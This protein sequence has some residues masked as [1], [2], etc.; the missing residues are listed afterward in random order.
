M[1][2]P[3]V[4]SIETLG[5]G[6]AVMLFLIGLFCLTTRRNVVKQ[7]FGLKIT[8]QGATLSLILAGRMHGDIWLAQA[9][10]IS[11]LV[12][13][14]IVIAIALALIINIY[15]HYPSGDVDHLDRLKG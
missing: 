11:A 2:L 12:V 15:L 8:L 9:M 6:A 4:W 7:V 1:N 13:E 3:A 14:T 10:V 5:L